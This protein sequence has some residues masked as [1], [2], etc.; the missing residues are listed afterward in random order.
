MLARFLAGEMD[1]VA[2]EDQLESL[3]WDGRLPVADDALLLLHEHANG[4]WT[5]EELRDGV[6]LLSGRYELTP[7]NETASTA[8]FTHQDRQSVRSETL[9]VAVSA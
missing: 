1:A 5:D 2:L 9:H 7:L 6:R 8:S 3:A 4:D